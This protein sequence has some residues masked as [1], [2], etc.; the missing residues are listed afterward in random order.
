MKKRIVWLTAVLLIGFMGFSPSHAQ[1]V[2]NLLVNGGFEDDVLSPWYE[3]GGATLEIVTELVGAAVPEGLVEEGSCLHVVVPTAGVNA[4][5]FGLAQEGHIFETG[6]YYTLSAFMK[7]KSGDLEI[8]FKPERASDPWEGYG[9]QTYIITEEWAEYSITTPVFTE[10]V[11]GS[12]TFHIGYAAGDFWV[13]GV[14][15]Y[16]GDYVEPGF[17]PTLTAKSPSP[18]DV[19][20]DVPQ[21]VVLSWEPSPFAATHDVYF[22]T[23]F[24]DVNDATASTASQAGTTYDPEGL[25]EFG[26][27]YYWR[28]DEVNAPPDSTVFKGNVWSFTVE[29]LVYPIANITATASSSEEGNDPADTINGSGLDADDL[30][31]M[32]ATDMWQSVL[33]EPG[34]IWIQYEFDKAYKLTEMWVWNYNVQ[35]EN[36]LGFGFKDVTITHSVDGVEWTAL[37]DYEFAQSPGEA[38][39]AHNTTID[40]GGLV[41]QYIRL[42]A[43][44]N[45]TEIPSAGL[46]EVRIYHLPV[47][48]REPQPALQ[49]FDVALDVVLGWRP[50]REAVSHEVYLSNDEQAVIDGTALA[51]AVSE[52][53]YLPA[54]LDFGQT[55]YWK[56]NEVNEA[57]SP[58]AYEGD[59]WNFST[60]EYFVVED[61]E[62]YNDYPPDEI[63]S[64]WIDGYLIPENGATVGYPAPDWNLDEHYVETTIVHGGAQ[65][66]PLFYDHNGVAAYSEAERTWDTPQDWTVN[67][68]DTLTLFFR[69]HPA[70]VGS[71]AEETLGTYTM[72][73]S[74]ADIWVPPDGFHY[75]YKRL[76][77]AGTIQANILS[78][79]NT[80]QYAKTGVMIRDTLDADSA[81]AM[82]VIHAGGGVAFQRRVTAGDD[83][84]EDNIAGINAPV[85]VKLERA[86]GGM[87][88]AW[89]STD[90]T[91]WEPLGA[92]ELIPMALDVNIGLLLCSHDVALTCQAELSDVQI[93]GAVSQQWTNQD[94]GILTNT[95]E[96]M[97]VAL[98]DSTGATVTVYHNNPDAAQITTYTEWPIDLQAIADQGVNVAAVSKLS[99][100]VGDPDNPQL[101][102]SGIL[103][104]D[105]IQ[106]GHPIPIPIP[107]GINLLTNGGFEDGV[108]DPWYVGGDTTA[109]VV[110]EL[111]G[112]AVPED[113][114][115][116]DFSLHITVNSAGTNFWDYGMNQG[117]YVF[118]A[119]KKYTLSAFL[120]CKE[121]TMEI[122]FKPE[123]SADPWSGYGEQVMTMTDEWAEYSV[124]TPVFAEDISPGS[125]TFHIGFAA[126]EFWMDGIRFYEGE[127]APT[128]PSDVLEVIG[129]FEG[130]LDGWWAADATLSQSTTGATTGT[131]A[132]QVD[133]P[134][135]WHMNALLDL[136]PHRASLGTPGA[137]ITA[138]VTAFDA[139]MTTTWMQVQMVINAQN[140]DDAGAN[141]N[142]GWQELDSQDVIRDGQPHTYTWVL[143]D[144]L[145]SA[146]AGADDN[147]SW[148]EL[149]LVT[150]LDGASATKF[151][152]DNIQLVYEVPTPTTVATVV[153]DWEND[154]DG[155]WANDATL[156]FSPT[157][158]TLGAQAL[159]A[160]G[161]GGWHMNASLDLK[162]HRASL[163]NPGAMI[164]ADVTAFDAD[165]TTTWMEVQMIINAQ[166]N[167]DNGANNNIGWQELGS[168]NVIR[169]GQTYTYTWE[170]PDSLTSAIAGADDNISWFE[171]VLVTNLDGASATKFY[172]DNVQLIY[173]AP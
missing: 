50:G 18:A 100:G 3:Y 99:I 157:G 13:D 97:Y 132:L 138:D 30:H 37:G 66:M 110:T 17:K 54:P 63:W 172:I 152:I 27:T 160:D 43:N 1:E 114:I 161:P 168:Q 31:S 34:P 33:D 84:A 24:D 129:D 103:Y 10:D 38:G 107:T 163:G 145:T 102:A 124:T 52:S 48:A 147:I 139:D 2:E 134:G 142:I 104:I 126:G 91:T 28:I 112:A 26:Q 21:D 122:N 133:G 51:D 158:A 8:G 81:Y 42:T 125:I 144:S 98:A 46:S 130:S 93:T 116:G 40:L 25:L 109:E 118:E 69:G 5:D 44:T 85:W 77:G 150:N 58:R 90:G 101:N 23:S 108:I 137:M 119:G 127:P 49:E 32:A 45:W 121:G 62:D 7:S 92:P 128:E 113:P 105:D 159:Q 20:T 86:A 83:T 12:I 73:G 156:S 47:H 35:F 60:I 67:G 169:D 96:P 148:F 72:T 164:T 87:F 95:P 173:E 123:L 39:L 9:S 141:N 140:N 11:I 80:H 78:I 88:T 75:A 64:T 74:G 56:V 94:V 143:P 120:K 115:E 170:L 76:S 154:M 149:A 22:G 136:K 146:I 41:A 36:F 15:W 131:E 155:W 6:K 135:G 167:D 29:P 111:V 71:F 166:G 59:I 89:Y 14:R 162:P 68:A 153:G 117:G 61:F 53:L 16:E 165:M 57:A 65:A 106:V 171:L 19:A 82:V 151:Y 70:P 55:Y 4:W 79:D